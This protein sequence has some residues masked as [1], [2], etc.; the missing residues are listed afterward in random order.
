MKIKRLTALV[1]SALLIL[2]ITACKKD[3]EPAAEPVPG[4][5]GT[6]ASLVSDTAPAQTEQSESAETTQPAVE[7]VE[8]YNVEVYDCFTATQE[9]YGDQCDYAIPAVRVNGKELETVNAQIWSD[10]YDGIYLPEVEQ[11][12]NEY[13]ELNISVIEYKWAYSRGVLS[14]IADSSEYCTDGYFYK[15]YNILVPEDRLIGRTEFLA[16][17]GMTEEDFRVTVCDAVGSAC[18]DNGEEYRKW[19]SDDAEVMAEEYR[20]L[21]LTAAED[22]AYDCIPFVG[23]GEKIWFVGRIYAASGAGEY[24]SVIP[25]DYPVSA[26]YLEALEH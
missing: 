7:P 17:F 1:L 6:G 3:A 20:L 18:W 14:I 9:M 26:G 23:E 8:E 11:P 10:L 5:A 22:N 19:F 24:W 15:V 25:L 16:A 21:K 4:G 2:S 13:G 12:L